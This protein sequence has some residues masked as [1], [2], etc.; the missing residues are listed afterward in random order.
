[1][2]VHVVVAVGDRPVPVVIGVVVLCLVLDGGG[3]AFALAVV[4]EGG[5]EKVGLHGLV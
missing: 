5:R 2:G 1:M 4:I 3:L